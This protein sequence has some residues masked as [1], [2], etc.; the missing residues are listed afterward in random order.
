MGPRTVIF[1]CALALIGV[2]GFLLLQTTSVSPEGEVRVGKVPTA[3]AACTDQAPDRCRPPLHGEGLEGSDI[4]EKTLEGKIVLVNFWATW[5]GPCIAEMP[6]LERVW[7]RHQQDGFVIVG[8]VTDGR[9]EDRVR[10]VLGRRGVT[11][12]VLV[13]TRELERKFGSPDALPTSFLYDA[14]GHL[15]R[16]WQGAIRERDLETEVARLVAGAKADTAASAR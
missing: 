7:K 9:D 14:S 16:R 5:C 4:S 6:A 12:P 11:Y 15:V 1:A 2:G 10:D 13:S 8:I 3:Q